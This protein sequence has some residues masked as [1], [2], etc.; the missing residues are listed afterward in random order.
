[1]YKGFLRARKAL[2]THPLCVSPSTK[3]EKLPSQR[4]FCISKDSFNAMFY[5]PL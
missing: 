5:I 2:F 1:M 3:G 4:S